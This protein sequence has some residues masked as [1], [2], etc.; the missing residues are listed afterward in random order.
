MIRKMLRSR[1]FSLLAL[2][3][4]I[5]GCAE[6]G[7]I[8]P[9]IDTKLV[10]PPG[11]PAVPYPVDNE[12]TP[13]RVEFGRQLFFDVRLSSDFT[14]SCASCHKPELAFADNV[15]TSIGVAGRSGSRNAP[16]LMNTAYQ[17]YYLREGGV[18]TL[19][20]Q[21]LV[22]IQEHAEM[23]MNILDVVERLKHETRYADLAQRTYGRE[24]DPWVLTRAI[25]SYERSLLSKGSAYDKY[26]VNKDASALTPAAKRGMELFM[27]ERTQCSSCH[28]GP[29]FTSYAFENNG[30]YTDYVDEGRKRLTGNESDRALFKVPS[31][32][33]AAL[34]APYMHDGSLKTLADVVMHYSSGG[35]PHANKSA[36]IKP[37]MLTMDEQRDIV[38]F[39]ESLTDLP[40]S[41]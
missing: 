11:F 39:L 23:D 3:L 8:E 1:L 37:L 36:L 25:S 26:V 33:N 20:M 16:S 21:V 27:S 41:F 24:L 19:E 14:V 7:T 29:N 5:V 32:R 13:E 2:L 6:Q 9:P 15:A 4:T 31:L 22:P 34:T 17:P 10:A 35:S 18:P 38:A 30:L 12:P 40:N 28:A